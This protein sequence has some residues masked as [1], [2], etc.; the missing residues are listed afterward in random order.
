MPKCNCDLC[1]RT[2][3]YIAIAKR[4]PQKDKEAII[5]LLQHLDCVEMDRDVYQATLD[6]N[7]PSTKTLKEFTICTDDECTWYTKSIKKPAKCPKC[8][9]QTSSAI[10]VERWNRPLA[11]KLAT[12]A[13]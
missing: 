2:R 13:A 8:G 11:S 9:K 12:E 4:C 5:E 10:L 6:G 7:W 1:K 3:K